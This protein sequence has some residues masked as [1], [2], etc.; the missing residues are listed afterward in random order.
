NLS[1]RLDIFL[2]IGTRLT[3]YR[4]KLLIRDFARVIWENQ[5]KVVFVNLTKL[6]KS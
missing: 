1:L 5:G 3:T 6:A 4:V 2:I